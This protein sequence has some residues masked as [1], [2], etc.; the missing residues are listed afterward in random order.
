M[1]LIYRHPENINVKNT[2]GWTPLMLACCNFNGDSTEETI[3]MLL[4]HPNIDVNAIIN[5]GWTSLIV[6]CRYCTTEPIKLLLEHPKI[7]VNAKDNLGWTALIHTCQSCSTRSEK[8][9]KLLLDHPNIDVNIKN[10]DGWTALMYA[11][12]M[13][14]ISL[15]RNIMELLLN[16]PYSGHPNIIINSNDIND[17]NSDRMFINNIKNNN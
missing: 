11:R 2:E 10:N 7:D 15:K 5:I 12:R 9:V 17:D 8:I 13:S 14:A 4:N 16:H 6:A 3:Q 1:Q